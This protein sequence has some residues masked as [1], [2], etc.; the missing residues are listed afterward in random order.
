MS[1]KKKCEKEREPMPAHI[2]I[3]D[4]NSAIL[5]MMRLVLEEWGGYHVTVASTLFEEI[6]DVGILRPD[7]ILL[8]LVFSKRQA[9]WDFLQQLQ[10]HP[11][12]R[13]IP[14]ILCTAALSKTQEAEAT[15]WQK[16]IHLLS[17]PFH[18]NELLRLVKEHL[19]AP[20]PKEDQTVTSQ[21]A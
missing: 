15:H 20:I 12:T 11:H 5:E 19:E 1:L 7:L 17:K 16:D 4:D 3:L 21:N 9:G 6:A 18:I 2:L 13:Q 14:V 8:D 10:H